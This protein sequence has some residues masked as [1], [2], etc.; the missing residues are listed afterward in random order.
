MNDNTAIVIA[1][2]TGLLLGVFFYGTLWWTVRKTLS[3]SQPG[4]WQLGSTVVRMSLTLAGFY[5]VGIGLGSSGSGALYATTG[6][7]SWQL[8][9]SCLVGFFIAR[10]LLVR[11]LGGAPH[12]P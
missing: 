8:M 1:G 6:A 2:L 3:S 11:I 10:L 5:M 4:W 9:L 12:A 7:A